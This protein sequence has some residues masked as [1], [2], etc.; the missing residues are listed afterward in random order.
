MPDASC[1]TGVRYNLVWNPGY[2]LIILDILL[3]RLFLTRI[4]V[5]INPMA[6]IDSRA[7]AWVDGAGCDFIY[8]FA[9]PMHP[10]KL[11]TDALSFGILEIR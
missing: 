2:P 5:Y 11:E 7:V 4:P 9:C 1:K 6:C 10:I 8:P 3:A